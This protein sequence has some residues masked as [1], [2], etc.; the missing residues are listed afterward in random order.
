MGIT[1]PGGLGTTIFI[2][3]DNNGAGGHAVGQPHTAAEISAAFPLDFVDL[4]TPLV[5]SYRSLV[6]VQS[7]DGVGTNVTTWQDTRIRIMWDSGRTYLT[8]SVG[9]SNRWTKW[10]TLATGANGEPIG[11]DGVV[12]DFGTNPG[13]ANGLLGNAQLYGC[14]L[15]NYNAA[16]ASSRVFLQPGFAGATY[17]IVDCNVF[18]LAGTQSYGS[19]TSQV[20]RMKRVQAVSLGAG[21]NG[22]IV[23]FNCP[24]SDRV[25][26]YFPNGD[27]KMNTGG[28][29]RLAYPN[30]I[31]PSSL[32]EARYS[33]AGVMLNPTWSQNTIKPDQ[34]IPALEEWLGFGVLL[35]DKDLLP[36]EGARVRVWDEF[37]GRYV[38]DVN[39]GPLGTIDFQAPQ[40]I[41]EVGIV[42]TPPFANALLARGH[43]ND[44]F[45]WEHTF[46]LDIN[47]D[48]AVP[49]PSRSQRFTFPYSL[50]LGTQRQY[51][52]LYLVI[53]LE[54]SSTGQEDSRPFLA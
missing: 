33:V 4:G 9:Q 42:P 49:Y 29:V 20:A 8:S 3:D 47:S 24:D 18:S 53:Q 31:G 44:G 46:T 28:Y 41:A 14:Q 26:F 16:A 48:G 50:F 37:D 2:Y 17:D 6:T 40:S 22:R 32:G 10:G 15:N 12:A 25:S 7:G 45:T 38:V 23:Q 19:S 1:R 30:F 36:I 13:S 35:L 43:N 21:T 39:T 51:Q 52:P 11:Y 54:P 5:R 27:Y 34:I